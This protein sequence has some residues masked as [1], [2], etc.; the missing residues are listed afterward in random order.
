MHPLLF[1]LFGLKIHSYGVLVAIAFLVGFALMGYR[2]KQIG[3]N[4]DDYLEAGLWL[5][6][7]GI[8]GARLF[9]FLWYPQLFFQNPIGTLLSSGGLV[10]YGG[11]IGVIIAILLYTR[12]KK[13]SL[14]LF[15]DLLSPSAALGL[16]IGRVGCL[17]AGCCFGSPCTLPWAI[18]YPHTH[19]TLGAAVHPTPLYETG[20][21]LIATVLL[22]KLD[23]RK[24]FIG[25]TTAWFFIIAGIVRFLVEY[26]RGD[27]LVWDVPIIATLNLSASQVVSLIGIAGGI[28]LLMTLAQKEKIASRISPTPSPYLPH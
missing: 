25:Y 23:Q 8:G 17:L 6:I 2:A 10:W 21:M 12:I 22:L 28:L 1:D 20:L 19:E 15:G 5:I 24:P 14:L 3:E 11:V 27:R 13:M 16:A 26:V 7:A 4:P 9:Y 18:H